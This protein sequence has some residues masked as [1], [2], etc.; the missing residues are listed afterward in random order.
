MAI[1]KVLVGGKPQDD[2]IVAAKRKVFLIGT[3][4]GVLAILVIWGIGLRQ[5]SL[6]IADRFTLPLLAVFF[7]TLTILFWQQ[8][9][10]LRSFEFFIYGLVVAFVLFE[11]GSIIIKITIL[12]GSF[13]PGITLWLPFVYILSFLILSTNRALL[14]SS[15]FFL[16]TL[17]IGVASIIRFMAAGLV[18][19][20]M[21]L[22]VQVYF[23]SIFYVAVL[24]LVTR[25]KDH[26]ISEHMRAGDLTRLAM[27][28]SLTQ[29]DNRRL[30]TQLLKEDV[31]RVDRDGMPLSVIL[32]DLDRF[33]NINDSYGH[34]TGDEVL[35][36]VAYQLRQ[37]IRTSDPFGRWGGDEFLV[38]ATNTDGQQA[39]ELAQRMRENLENCDFGPAGKVTASFGISTYQNGDTPE[40]LIRRADMGLY[41]AK[42][43]GRNRVEAVIAGITLPLFE[44]DKPYPVAKG[45]D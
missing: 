1:K 27:I 24:Y 29:V 28:D 26:Y 30:L 22:L 20:N 23:A 5:A 8:L 16:A 42:S 18:F 34:N 39:V 40:T 25:I 13:V 38:L 43:K 11:F 9:I 19:P 2:P 6:S 32:F 12:H 15:I 44:G 45:Q 41:K 7:L 37:V 31:A 36:Q 10:H 17:I 14:F 35:R 33:K 4:V 3:P 21:P